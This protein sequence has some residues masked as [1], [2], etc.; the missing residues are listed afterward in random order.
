MTL[1]LELAAR[2]APPNVAVRAAKIA[3][4]RGYAAEAYAFPPL[5]PKFG[6]AGGNAKLESALLHAL[7]RQ[8]SEAFW[9]WAFV[10]V[11]RHTGIRF[12]ELRELSH[13][14]RVGGRRCHCTVFRNG[15]LL[16]FN[17]ERED[18]LARRAGR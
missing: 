14:G 5:L 4:L 6:P 1:A 7:T 11:L 8:E 16:A 3:L 17:G 2:A 9:A 13:H 10:E 15:D 12:E 18:L